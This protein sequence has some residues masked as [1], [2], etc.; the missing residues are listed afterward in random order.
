MNITLRQLRYFVEIAQSRSFSRAAEHL[1]V[2]Q[3]ALSQ[4]IAS[5]EEDLGTQLF[6][7]HAKGVELSASGERLLARAQ[8]ILSQ[9]SALKDQVEGREALPSGLVR[10][11]IAGSV[12]SVLIAPLLRSMAENYPDIQLRIAEGLSSE[13][14]AQIESGQTH[15]A[16]MPSPSELQGMESM[17][18]FEEHFMVFG[19]Y[20]AMKRRPQKLSFAEVAALP[21]AEPDGAHDLRKIIERAAS[22]IDR[23]LDIRYE[24]NSP[25]LLVAIVKGGLAYSIMPPSACLEA[26]AAK[27]VAGRVLTE[28]E[29]SRVQAM[30][31]PR[32]RPLTPAAEV[33][34][35]SVVRIVRELLATDLLHGRL[36]G[37][38]HKKK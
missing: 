35:D 37:A 25:S 10:L 15:L 22:A 21:L 13:V 32:D 3:P 30:V 26:V 9:T 19:A 34:R 11:S 20:S 6:K 8:A 4:N 23:K 31:W 33:V 7:R 17:P 24:L 27:S 16:L 36:L 29:L 2:A 18:V 14:R 1:S 12:S 38:S 5:L 28:P